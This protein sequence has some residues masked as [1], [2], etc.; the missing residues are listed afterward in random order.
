M[1]KTN[2]DYWTFEDLWTTLE[3]K[4]PTTKDSYGRVAFK[5]PS[6]VMRLL[7]PISTMWQ[8]KIPKAWTSGLTR[9]AG[10]LKDH[11]TFEEF[12]EFINSLLETA[13]LSLE[14][15]TTLFKVQI[16]AG[17]REGTNGT[18][19]VL[20]LR[21]QDINFETR[22]CS[23]R[24]KGGRGKAGR[25]WRQ[26]PLDLF[27][28]LN[29]FEDLKRYW[30]KQGKPEKGKVFPVTYDQYRKQFHETRKRGNGRIAGHSETLRPHIIRKTHAQWLVKLWV[31]LEE[32]CGQ[33][34]TGY[35]GVGWDN[36]EILL[37]YY[38]ELEGEKR[39]K[40]LTVFEERKKALGLEA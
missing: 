20:G 5:H 38:I 36:P 19:G 23:A 24:E 33:F 25:I 34:P 35:F 10:E 22:R 26:L 14:G 9:E 2:P 1:N 7:S 3:K 15:W 27:T 8:G 37:K 18:T 28:W 31:P 21:W 13:E 6:A 39:Q 40:A 11:F 12:N 4:L 32:I 30:E 16:N 17:L 29:A